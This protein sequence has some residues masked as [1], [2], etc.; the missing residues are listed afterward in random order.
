[1]AYIWQ[2]EK[3][4]KPSDY[5]SYEVCILLV[6]VGKP[7][8]DLLPSYNVQLHGHADA[9]ALY[10]DGPTADDKKTEIDYIIDLFKSGCT[11][12]KGKFKLD[13]QPGFSY[14]RQTLV[15]E[16]FTSYRKSATSCFAHNYS[17][18]PEPRDCHEG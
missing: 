11:E 3:F 4:Q 12:L 9:Y 16:T 18:P 14:T 1:M 8:R 2:S 5:E 15:E 10:A 6:E 17:P 13:D 7:V